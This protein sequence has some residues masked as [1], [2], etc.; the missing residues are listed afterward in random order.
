MERWAYE[1]GLPLSSLPSSVL[2]PSD[3]K[4]PVPVP[5][6]QVVGMLVGWTCI[7]EFQIRFDGYLPSQGSGNTPPGLG[8]RKIPMAGRSGQLF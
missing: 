1:T 7:S 2:P 3:P 5:V 6:L 4:I 8:V